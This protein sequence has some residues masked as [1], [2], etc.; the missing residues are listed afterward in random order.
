MIIRNISHLQKVRIAG[1]INSFT[2]NFLKNFIL[3]NYDN[4]NA[5]QVDNLA[6]KI[7]TTLGGKPSFKNYKPPFSRHTFP[8]SITVS[9]NEEIVHGL[10]LES[11][12]FKFGDVVSIDCG[13]SYEGFNVDSAITF[14]IG[15][16]P[17]KIVEV[18]EKS[19]YLAIKNIRHNVYIRD[20]GKIV[21]DFVKSSGFSVIKQLTGHGVGRKLHD[22]PEIPN[23]YIPDYNRK[24][25][26]GMLVAI[27]PMISEGS[28]EIEVLDDEWTIVTKD[29]S[30]SAHFE[31]TVWVNQDG[32]EILTTI[33][34]DIEE[35]FI[36]KVISTL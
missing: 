13:T 36:R 3:Q 10:P 21:E 6:Y 35:S 1:Y 22:D 12:K 20:V 34:E 33:P 16:Q 27:E 32:C 31:H 17:R 19:L 7:I 18:C 29:R 26:Y 2:L 23:F 8:Y 28:W 9:I 30:I 24:F 25:Y 15:T 5:K 11:K 4:I 14:T